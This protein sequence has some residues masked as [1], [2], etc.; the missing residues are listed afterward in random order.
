MCRWL[1]FK[2]G[3]F[4][5]LS[6]AF[7]LVELKFLEKG[8]TPADKV[9]TSLAAYPFFFLGNLVMIKIL[10]YGYLMRVCWTFAFLYNC[11]VLINYFLLINFDPSKNYKFTII[12]RGI[13]TVLA[14]I[15]QVIPV[16]SA[17][18]NSIAHP[19]TAA[20]FVACMLVFGIIA[21][22][23]PVSIGVAVSQFTGLNL[24][25]WILVPLQYVYLCLTYTT[26]LKC[27]QVPAEEYKRV[28]GNV[29][30]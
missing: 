13:I 25:F 24:I 9:L 26:S 10:K 22:W 28:L 30:D 2:L 7:I 8:L 21:N 3:I 6:I 15:F 18:Y 5:G 27:D 20:N 12:A 23:M 19:K 14:D 29:N 11:L 17:F 16:L 4:V 1:K